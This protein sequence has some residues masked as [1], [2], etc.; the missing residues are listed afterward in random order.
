[1]TTL[2]CL[3]HGALTLVI[4]PSRQ[5]CMVC[6][7]I[8]AMRNECCLSSMRRS[9]SRCCIHSQAG[10]QWIGLL[11]SQ[12][13][14]I[15]SAKLSTHAACKLRLCKQHTKPTQGA[16]ASGKGPS[17]FSSQG[18]HGGDIHHLEVLL[19]N[20]PVPHVL[21]HLM[22]HGKHGNVGLA[23]PGGGTHQQVLVAVECCGVDAAL[24]AVQ[25]PAACKKQVLW[26]QLLVNECLLYTNQQANG[27]CNDDYVWGW[28]GAGG[29]GGGGKRG[30]KP[31]TVLQSKS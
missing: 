24:N 13:F 22:Q 10:A 29:R 18:L 2:L 12:G 1:M 21:P 23:S 8:S 30:A 14:H 9:S 17:D 5:C 15:N 4:T 19:L 7:S 28:G 3:S 6:S 16:K 31:I 11:Q 26:R 20:D 27:A 25:G